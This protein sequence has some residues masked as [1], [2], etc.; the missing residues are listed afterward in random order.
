MTEQE[1]NRAVQYVTAATSYGRDTVAD[2]LHVGFS[3]LTNLATTTSH[4]FDRGALLEYVCQWVIRRTGYPEPQ[5][6]EVFGFASQWLDQMYDQV[7]RE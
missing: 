2:I 7:S 1:V 6:R 3:E 4:T 5:V